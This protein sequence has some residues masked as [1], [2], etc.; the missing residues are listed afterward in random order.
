M[1]KI[2]LTLALVLSF[3][4]IGDMKVNAAKKMNVSCQRID[5]SGTT[6]IYFQKVKGAKYY[7]VRTSTVTVMSKDSNSTITGKS[8]KTKK[9]KASKLKTQKNYM[10]SGK[11]MLYIKGPKLSKKKKYKQYIYA[12]NAK[13]RIIAKNSIR[14]KCTHSFKRIQVKEMKIREKYTYDYTCDQC[15]L[16]SSSADSLKKHISECISLVYANWENILQNYADKYLEG[17]LSELKNNNDIYEK[18][19]RSSLFIETANDWICENTPYSCHGYAT[20]GCRTYHSNRY[21]S[22]EEKEEVVTYNECTKCGT[23]KKTK[24]ED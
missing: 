18:T 11:R 8:V 10:T 15:G 5:S 20:I 12:I 17:D 4:S 2:I 21:V 22:T 16:E 14:T 1:K 23:R 13:G 19:V 7:K 3:I 9:Y 6:R 24:I